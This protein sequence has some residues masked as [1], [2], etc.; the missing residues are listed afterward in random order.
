MVRRRTLGIAE[1][2][3]WGVILVLI[4]ISIVGTVLGSDYLEGLPMAV[5]F[6]FFC[7]VFYLQVLQG[8]LPAEDA[9]EW[10]IAVAAGAAQPGPRVQISQAA[11]DELHI[12]IG[13]AG[14]LWGWQVRLCGSWVTL[15]SG[16]LAIVIVGIGVTQGGA[17]WVLPALALS[18]VL[19]WIA[20]GLFVGTLSEG[21]GTTYLD[22]T[23]DRIHQ[24]VVCWNRVWIERRYRLSPAARVRNDLRAVEGVYPEPQLPRWKSILLLRPPILAWSGSLD[25][26]DAHVVAIRIQNY[27]GTRVGPVPSLA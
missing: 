27:L 16:M 24:R 22:F 9:D 8:R 1:G 7:L 21:W 18:A 19:A 13:P 14:K 2:V 25:A 3:V 23:S 4:L 11:P 26:V 10:A 6:P 12:R 17:A 15:C 20:A 5:A